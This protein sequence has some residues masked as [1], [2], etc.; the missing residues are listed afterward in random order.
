M[1]TTGH[2]VLQRLHEWATEH[3]CKLSSLKVA[4]HPS[5]GGYGLFNTTS[6][7]ANGDENRRVALFIP[8]HLI[9]SIDTVQLAAEEREELSEVLNALPPL[10][11]PSHILT[12]FILYLFHLRNANEDNLF[13]PYVDCLPQQ[14]LLPIVWNEQELQLLKDSNT[15]ISAPVTAKVEWMKSTFDVLQ[16]VNG[17]FQQIPWSLYLLAECC[18]TSRT[19]ENPATNT[20]MLVPILDM[21]NH[22][23]SRNAAWEFTDEGIQLLREPVDISADEEITISYDLNKGTGEMLFNYG[24]IE[25]IS[26]DIISNGVVLFGLDRP[27]V[28]G[29]NVFRLTLESLNDSFR[30]LSF[31]TY[32]NW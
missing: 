30:H 7:P 19:L 25:N 31:L 32:A 9:I 5:Y 11:S 21:A 13:S 27:P 18:V 20:P 15:S 29:G 14:S 26:P 6:N 1:T 28:P 17:W 4:S 22:S 12:I 8:N 16:Q 10:P 24:F 3:G 23:Y 2:E